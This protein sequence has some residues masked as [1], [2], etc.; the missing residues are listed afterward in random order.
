MMCKL[1]AWDLIAK[2]SNL[3]YFGNISGTVRDR[4]LIFGAYDS[5]GS[6]LSHGCQ[7]KFLLPGKHSFGNISGTMGDRALTFCAYDSSR[8]GLSYGC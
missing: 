1:C 3:E 7:G 5:S 8:S 4:A 6:G 2:R